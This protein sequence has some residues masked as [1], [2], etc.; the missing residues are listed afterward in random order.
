MCF[1]IVTG[2]HTEFSLSQAIILRSVS[3]LDKMLN[4]HSSIPRVSV[5]LDL[6]SRHPSL[7]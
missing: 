7:V 2:P 3:N 1:Q 5:P 6:Y 4:L